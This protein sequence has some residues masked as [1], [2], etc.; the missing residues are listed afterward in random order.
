MSGQEVPLQPI[1]GT[2]RTGED[3]Q[4]VKSDFVVISIKQ[5]S[6]VFRSKGSTKDKMLVGESWAELNLENKVKASTVPAG[7]SL[8]HLAPK[9]RATVLPKPRSGPRK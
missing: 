6:L 7:A 3:N 2:A 8:P 5:K 4:W 9:Q 1:F